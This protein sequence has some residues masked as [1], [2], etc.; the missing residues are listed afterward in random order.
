METLSNSILT[1]QIAEHGAELQSIKKG[2]KEYLWQGDSKFWGRRSPILFPFVGRVWDN[3][4]RHEGKT[5]E[6][7]QHGFAR[8]MDFRITY[9]DD[10]GIVF[11]LE[12]TP[13]TL[14][15]YPFPFRLMVGYL[16]EDNKL[17]V[18]WRVDNL[19]DK[20]VYF[21]I[22]A[23]PAF[24]LPDFN[25][26]DEVRGYFGLYGPNSGRE[27]KYT[28]PAEKGCVSAELHTLN[29]NK[30]G[31]MP[32]TA[33]TFDHDTFI[34]ENQHLQKVMLDDKNQEPYITVDFDA[35]LVALW[36]PT[37]Q[38]PDCPF[39]CIE[40][41]YGRCDSVGYEGELKDRAWMQCL[42]SMENFD[43]SYSIRIE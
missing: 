30:E 7:G 23:H 2:S 9:K 17:T 6:M 3:K 26:A 32:I 14:E 24:N 35:P 43:V 8:D 12:S 29:L 5:Y 20:D 18:K 37:K 27:L 16:L 10:N 36:S 4:F 13:E 39:V 38:H 22:G 11:W 1:V 41:W 25:P 34:F 19:S 21:Q 31:L 33:H 42:K 15:K 28:A 40:P